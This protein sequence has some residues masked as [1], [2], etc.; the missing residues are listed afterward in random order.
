MRSSVADVAEAV[1]AVTGHH[2]S[3]T[4][5]EQRPRR[6]SHP[7]LTALVEA[8]VSVIALAS[9]ATIPDAL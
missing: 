7:T 9:A 5:P 3:I 4:P 8:E 1:G 2:S 6:L